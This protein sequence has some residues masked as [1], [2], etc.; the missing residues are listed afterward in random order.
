VARTIPFYS[1]R[2][3]TAPTELPVPAISRLP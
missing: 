1:T 3:P 2:T